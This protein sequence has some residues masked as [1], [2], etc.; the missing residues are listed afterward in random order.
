MYVTEPM[1]SSTNLFEF[2]FAFRLNNAVHFIHTS[3][4]FSSASLDLSV[5]SHW[6]PYPLLLKEQLRSNAALQKSRYHHWI[7]K[8]IKKIP[9]T[10]CL[11][12]L[13]YQEKCHDLTCLLQ[14]QSNGVVMIG[15]L[16]ELP[17]SHGLFW[18]SSAISTRVLLRIVWRIAR[19]ADSSSHG[20][21]NWDMM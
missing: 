17:V 11:S 19:R 20:A 18:W 16:F 14:S 5:G 3:W 13:E 4:A 21:S 6:I 8:T 7:T 2:I 12:W 15:T 1:P 9:F 10:N